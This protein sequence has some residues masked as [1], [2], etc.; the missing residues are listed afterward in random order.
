MQ[1][2]WLTVAAQI[3]NFLVLVWLLQRFLYRPITNA[4]RRREDR[5]EA[6][7]AEA[8][9]TRAKAEDEAR[10]LERREADL[11]AEREA[12]VQGARDEAEALRARLE[13]EIRA[14]TEDR[15]DA[16][17][18][19]LDH[20]RANIV[21]SLRKQAGR[22]V[23]R[24]AGRILSDYGDADIAERAAANFAQRLEGLDPDTRQ[25]LCEAA[26]GGDRTALVQTGVAIESAAKARI[27]RAIHEALS[28]GI[29]VDYHEDADMILGVRLTIGDHTVEWSAKRYLDR[30]EAE[31]G[32]IIDT[33]LRGM[34]RTGPGAKKDR[35]TA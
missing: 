27:T 3:V 6:R 17:L 32:E 14:E 23:L 26:A 19:Q 33:D 24:V 4:M 20:E 30:L 8:R 25:K 7:L 10:R 16:W 34:G 2:D 5:I 35:A 28:T 15:R 12:I 31:L 29:D 9:E 13:D 18:D 22:K 21:A 11:K 1:I